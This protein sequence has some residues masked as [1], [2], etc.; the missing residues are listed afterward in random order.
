M[1]AKQ[2]AR[3]I[4]FTVLDEDFIR[5]LSSDIDCYYCKTNERTYNLTKYNSSIRS[6]M[7]VFAWVHKEAEDY[8][9][10][11]TRNVWVKEA[12][13]RAREGGKA[14]EVTGFPRD[15]QDG[16]SVCLDAKNGYQQT[17]RILR[18]INQVR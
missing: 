2:P 4:E 11:A 3:T 14:L 17:V 12:Q 10:V 16:D 9:W 15:I 5:Q 7:G 18:Q 6:E 13:A 8:F 1:A